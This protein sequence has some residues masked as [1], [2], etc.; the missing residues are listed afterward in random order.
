VVKLS[1]LLASL[2][3]SLFAASSFAQRKGPIF[4]MDEIPAQRMLLQSY[5]PYNLIN[6]PI[7][8]ARLVNYTSA[9]Q[10]LEE[11]DFDVF[12]SRVFRHTPNLDFS[13]AFQ[14]HNMGFE[15]KEKKM[16]VIIGASK[17]HCYFITGL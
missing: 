14:N 13:L 9:Y 16:M 6:A 15:N 5:V 10:T 3:L 7:S 8:N 12:K 17:M 2:A 11:S 4:Q 1:K